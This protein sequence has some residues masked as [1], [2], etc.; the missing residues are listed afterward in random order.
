MEANSGID[1]GKPKILRK[2]F[3]LFRPVSVKSKGQRIQSPNWCVR[4]QHQGKRTCRSLGTPDYR[5]AQQRAKALVASVRQ[6]GWAS[7]VTLP[8]RHHSITVE[9]FIERYRNTAVARGL[10][11]RSIADGQ[12]TLRRVARE[13]GARR[14]ADITAAAL[15]HWIEDCK[16]KPV[17]LRSVLKNAGSTFARGALQFMGLSDVAN[18]FARLIRPKVDREPFSA[19]GRA[20]IM[21]LMTEGVKSLQGDA[22]TAFVLALGCGLRWGEI[23]SLTWENVLANGVRVLASLAKGR[24]QRVVPLAE[25]V[26]QVLEPSRREG[27]VLRGDARDVHASLCQWLRKR[28]VKDSK[29]VHYL[30][31]CYGSLAVADHGIFIASKLLGHSSIMLTASTYA[32]Q[33]DQLPAVKF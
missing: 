12:K 1:T 3:D 20:W 14:L 15:Q 7:A 16:L 19:P 31:K 17:T 8:T 24:R 26:L 5:Q 28:G 32:G 9:D 13:I 22:R 11:P 10:R 18:P 21:S 2:R 33:V 23:A 4:F 6:K 27:A 30:R 29:P 25:S